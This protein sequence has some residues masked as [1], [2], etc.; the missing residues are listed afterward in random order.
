ML[1]SH[2]NVNCLQSNLNLEVR[3][4]NAWLHYNQL[5]LNVAKTDCILFIEKK[6]N[7][8]LH[9][10]EYALR[11]TDCIKYLGIHMDMNVSWNRHIQ[12][13]ETK[14]SAASGALYKLHKMF[15]KK[16]FYQFTTVSLFA[17]TICYYLL[18]QR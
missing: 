15:P 14:L 3:K 12:Q 17:F 8:T 2:K 18:G 11:Q 9:L 13:I 10:R 4:I 16:L 5:S 7:I 1:T 6:E